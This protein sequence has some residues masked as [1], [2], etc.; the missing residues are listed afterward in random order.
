MATA[1]FQEFRHLNEKDYDRILGLLHL[2]TN[3]PKGGIFHSAGPTA[4][5]G[6]R[7]FDIWESTG[8]WERFLNDRLLPAFKQAG[9]TE[10]PVT[11]VFPVHNMYVTDNVALR[12]LSGTTF[13][14]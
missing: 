2:D 8:A 4:S 14:A 5:G 7:V 12:K 10:E 11:E 1:M 9:I 13:R 3:P 6:W